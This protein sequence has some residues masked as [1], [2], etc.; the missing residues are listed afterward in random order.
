MTIFSLFLKIQPH[1]ANGDDDDADDDNDDDDDN[2]DDKW[3]NVVA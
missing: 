2:V 1:H 3:R